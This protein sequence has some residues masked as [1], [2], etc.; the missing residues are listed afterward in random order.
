[1]GCVTEP[2]SHLK[3]ANEQM[4]AISSLI[5]GFFKFFLAKGS[6]S[7]AQK[8]IFEHYCCEAWRLWVDS[9]ARPNMPR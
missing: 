3:T 5:K 4:F 8:A 2:E 1:M 6:F 7:F 9:R